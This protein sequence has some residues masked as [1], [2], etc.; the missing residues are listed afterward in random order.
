[1]TLIMISGVSFR[2]LGNIPVNKK[3]AKKPPTCPTASPLL[4]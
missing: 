3:P 1:M 4:A 2:R